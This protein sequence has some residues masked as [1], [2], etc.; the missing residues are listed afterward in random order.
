MGVWCRE[1]S[2]IMR[3]GSNPTV[4]TPSAPTLT[5]FHIVGNLSLRVRDWGHSPALQIQTRTTYNPDSNKS[6]YYV[7]RLFQNPQG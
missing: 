4:P 3:P 2:G 7:P 5:G 6:P 1:P